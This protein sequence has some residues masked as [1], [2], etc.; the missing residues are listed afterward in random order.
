MLSVLLGILKVIGLILLWILI[1]VF[2][3][4]LIILLV[5]IRY[6]VDGVLQSEGRKDAAVNVTW[7]LHAVSFTL[8]IKTANIK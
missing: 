5:P 3:L 7:L 1:I 8:F 6:R 2:A 4:L